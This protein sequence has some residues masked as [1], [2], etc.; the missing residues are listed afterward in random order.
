LAEILALCPNTD[1][2]T[3]G[4]DWDLT[5]Q[6]MF[7]VAVRDGGDLFLWISIRRATLGDIYYAF[8]TGRSGRD[9]QK[10]NPHGSHH[11]DGR[12]HH[13]SFKKKYSPRSGRSRIP[14]SKVRTLGLHDLLLLTNPAPSV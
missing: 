3:G 13:K 5:M 11:K 6:R 12:S 10:W 1:K 14:I 2:G 4:E 7:A 8:P 9:W